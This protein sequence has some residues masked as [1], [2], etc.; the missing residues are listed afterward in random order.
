MYRMEDKTVLITGAARGQ[1]RAHAIRFA[2]E[3]ANVILFDIASQ[4]DSVPYEMAKPA[5]LEETAAQIEA[6]DRRAIISRGD[7]RNGDDLTRAVERGIAEFGRIDGLVSNAGIWSLGPFWE[8]STQAW[9]DSI[10]VNLTGHWLAAKAVAPHLMEQGSGTI[11]FTASVNG[12]EAGANYAHYTAAKH[13][14]IGLMKTVAVELG[15]HGIRSHVVAPGFI[16]TQMNDYQGS[17]DMM[18]GAAPGEGT[19]EARIEASKHWSA[20]KGRSVIKP[21]AVSNAVVWLSSDET[22]DMTGLV[23]PVDAG[24]MVLPAYNPAP[25]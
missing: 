18:A 14:V 6:L 8:L 15:P 19:P 11:V 5:D 17:Y 1:G 2:E 12:L 16:D 10:D 3:G 9:Q 22:A 25:A 13:G 4:I 21:S 20:L 23:V 24:H 7:V